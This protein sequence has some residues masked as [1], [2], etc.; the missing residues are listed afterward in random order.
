MHNWSLRL[1][2]SYLSQIVSELKGQQRFF[3]ND[4]SYFRCFNF[5][6]LLVC[7]CELQKTRK[8]RWMSCQFMIIK[9]VQKNRI[10]IVA[11]TVPKKTDSKFSYNSN[12]VYKKNWTVQQQHSHNY[13]TSLRKKKINYGLCCSYHKWSVLYLNLLLQVWICSR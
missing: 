10:T 13:E 5:W 12:F 6:L 2:A 3:V 4:S 7:E 9:S 1:E 8:V 11:C